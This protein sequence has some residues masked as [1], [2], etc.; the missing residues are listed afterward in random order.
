[1]RLRRHGGAAGADARA[2]STASGRAALARGARGHRIV[3]PLAQRLRVHCGRALH[4]RTGA[5]WPARPPHAHGSD[6]ATTR[7]RAGRSSGVGLMRRTAH[8]PRAR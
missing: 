4:I 2:D 7:G 6:D 5:L 1:M 3:R 8:T